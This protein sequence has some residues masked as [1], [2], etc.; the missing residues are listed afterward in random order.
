MT[1]AQ[2][3]LILSLAASALLCADVAGVAG[4][5][6]QR[7]TSA[8]LEAV[9]RFAQQVRREDQTRPAARPTPAAARPRF[10]AAPAVAW[11]VEARPA[12]APVAH[13]FRFRLPPPMA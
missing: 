4:V 5:A 9:Q 10:A 6:G 1:R 12:H 11:P 2:Q 3:I 8:D 13:P 7:L